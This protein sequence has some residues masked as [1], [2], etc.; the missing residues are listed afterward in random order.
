MSLPPQFTY[1]EARELVP[2][3]REITRQADERVSELRAQAARAAPGSR[4]AHK[5]KEWVTAAINRWADDITALGALPKGLWTVDFDSGE[6]FYYCWSFD[7]ADLLYYHPY[8]EGFV[9]RKPLTELPGGT[10]HLL[11]N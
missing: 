9:G 2:Q 4:Q 10:P 6:G 8:E 7:E 1:A 5:L 11:L 3:V